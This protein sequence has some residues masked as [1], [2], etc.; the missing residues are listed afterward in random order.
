M[1]LSSLATISVSALTAI[2]FIEIGEIRQNARSA[3]LVLIKK[4]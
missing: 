2:N 4:A 3:E 1:S